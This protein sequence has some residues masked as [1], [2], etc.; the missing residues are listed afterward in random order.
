[1]SDI[2]VFYHKNCYDGFASAWVAWKKF[3]DKAE[4]IA[5]NYQTPIKNI[6][7]YYGKQ[8]YFLDVFPGKKNLEEFKRKCCQI[9]IIDHHLTIKRDIKKILHCL[10]DIKIDMKHS[11]SVLAWKYFFSEKKIPKLLLFIEDMDLW[12]FKMPFTREILASINLVDYNFQ[13]WS[14]L[15]KDIEDKN[16][17]KKY[18]EAGKKIIDY[19]NKIVEQII[20]KAKKVKVGKWKVLAANSSIL[21]S[22]IG[23]ALI[24]KLPPIAIIWFDAGDERRISL[25]SNGKVDVSKIAEKYGGGGHK[26]AAS[27]AIK[28]KEPFP[29]EK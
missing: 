26:C 3:K 14:R 18:I 29:W 25:R 4:Y 23:E 28:V 17:R 22:E 6:H 27:F 2:I 9:T 15:I 11:A 12:K 8:V 16:K 20:Q 5:L 10:F 1:M 21:I 13:K 19:Q 24:K 7:T